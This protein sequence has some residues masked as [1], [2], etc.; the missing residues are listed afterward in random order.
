MEYVVVSSNIVIS[1]VCWLKAG[2]TATFGAG[3][4]ETD[5]AINPSMV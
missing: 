2:F 1:K 3:E 4:G 5:A